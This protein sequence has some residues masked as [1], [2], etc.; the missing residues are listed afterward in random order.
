M[1]KR[2]GRL[3]NNDDNLTDRPMAAEVLAEYKVRY[4]ELTGGSP[5]ATSERLTRICG[6]H[7]QSATMFRWQLLKD[8]SAPCFLF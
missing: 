1:R 3:I 2:G 5:N 7:R 8:S 6:H 4:A